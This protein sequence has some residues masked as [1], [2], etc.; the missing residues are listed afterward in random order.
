[1]LGLLGFVQAEEGG[2]DDLVFVDQGGAGEGFG[3]VTVVGAVA[4]GGELAFFGGE[5]FGEEFLGADGDGRPA[6][7]VWLWRRAG[8]PGCSCGPVWDGVWRRPR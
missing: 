6:R 4:D 5:D 3:L 7:R 2:V 8:P 1:M